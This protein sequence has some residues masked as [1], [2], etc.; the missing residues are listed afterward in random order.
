MRHD[1]LLLALVILLAAAC[2]LCIEA[3]L[4]A[5]GEA[6]GSRKLPE[7]KLE[8][9]NAGFVAL[10]NADNLFSKY[11]A[12][13]ST[14]VFRS[15]KEKAGFQKVL[16]AYETIIRKY[17]NSEIEAN[18]RRSLF[19]VYQHRGDGKLAIEQIETIAKSFAGTKYVWGAYHG[20]ATYYLN[21]NAPAA[22]IPW[23]EKIPLPKVSRPGPNR[24]IRKDGGAWT[25]EDERRRRPLYK[26]REAYIGTMGP[27]VLAMKRRAKCEILL[28]KPDA[29]AGRYEKVMK[30]F[31]ENRAE[32]EREL[33]DEVRRPL[34]ERHKRDIHPVL[35]KWLM[36]RERVHEAAESARW[37]KE[38]N[39]V[40]CMIEA[41]PTEL[42]IGDPFVITVK[43]RNVS[44]KPLTFRYQD[45]YQAM[46]LQ[47]KDETGKVL[48]TRELVR[49]DWPMPKVFYRRID[50][51]KTF[52]SEIKGRAK[53]KFLAS[54]DIPKDLLQRP[55]MVDLRDIGLD[56]ERL[57]KLTVTLRL[58]ADEKTVK[59]GKHF[60][61]DAVW[62]GELASNTVALTIRRMTRQE[63]DSFIAD[64]RFGSEKEKRAAIKVLSA[65][66][67]S[68]VVPMLM[69]I[70]TVGKGPHLRA[71][72][73][74]LV[75]I[76][77]TSIL[78]DLK[79]LYNLKV[80]YG[81]ERSRGY[82]AGIMRTIK[83]LEAS[84]TNIR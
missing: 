45:L 58:K 22:A 53:L 77:D 75:R 21:C 65:N 48:K 8:D 15:E 35:R 32:L 18:A 41:K 55:V 11:K 24:R 43:I 27:W 20:V 42:R 16:S 12:M 30:I 59:E 76:Q 69:G 14:P 19:Y 68:K 70:L 57:G 4:C 44:D 64:L 82:E 66:A 26:T 33:C 81:N 78:P 73:D 61:F 50:A 1:R 34:G 83:G 29:A 71:A 6:T 60:G 7:M 54:K 80:K 13:H 10:E 25:A 36:E 52:T 79:A 23:L 17:P 72:S 40:R 46:K 2:V 3:R 62:T 37:G 9:R 67:D 5:Q 47:I 31:P 63:M 74:A 56:C 49:Y 38:V 51:G 28:G 39:G 84:K